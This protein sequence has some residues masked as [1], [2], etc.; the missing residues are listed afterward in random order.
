MTTRK[1]HICERKGPL[2]RDWGS[3]EKSSQH[4]QDQRNDERR[5][6]KYGPEGHVAK[7]CKKNVEKS[8]HKEKEMTAIVSALLTYESRNVKWI[9][10]FGS[11]NHV[12][13][14]REN[15]ISFIE[16][17]GQVRV[18]TNDDIKYVRYGVVRICSRPNEQRRPLS[19]IIYYMPWD[20]HVL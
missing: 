5:C 20:L 16:N 2:A 7:C 12:S 11:R 9:M 8:D 6:F 18:G 17:D 3:K 4:E 19:F 10:D 15:F 1:G 13:S 14:K